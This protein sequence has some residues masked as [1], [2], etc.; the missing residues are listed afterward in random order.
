M[1]QELVIQA[2]DPY[3]ELKN[4]GLRSVNA[5]LSLNKMNSNFCQAS[6]T[7]FEF[8]SIIKDCNGLCMINF[9]LN[10]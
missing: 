7:L 8:Y 5:C 9:F 1:N 3:F 4:G 10:F 6:E 2:E